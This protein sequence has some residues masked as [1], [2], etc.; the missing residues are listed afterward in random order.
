MTAPVTATSD[1]EWAAWLIAQRS[2]PLTQRIPQQ[3]WIGRP[4]PEAPGDGAQ[5]DR[6]DVA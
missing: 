2:S 3:R 4:Q 6:P 5:P 1:D